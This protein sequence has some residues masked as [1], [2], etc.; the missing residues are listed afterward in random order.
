MLI[1]LMLT[2]LMLIQ[3]MPKQRQGSTFSALV[4]LFGLL[5]LLA[6]PVLQAQDP[7]QSNQSNQSSNTQQLLGAR[8]NDFLPVEEAFQLN[9]QMGQEELLLHWDIAPDYYLYKAR[10][11]LSAEPQPQGFTL[12]FADNT[13]EIYD[14]YFEKNMDVYYEQAQIRIALPTQTEPFTLRLESQGCADA[15]LCYPPQTQYL[16]VDPESGQVN[17]TAAAGPGPGSSGSASG[18]ESET[19]AQIWLPYVL[20]MAL[21]GGLILNLMP[22]VF[23]VLSIKVMSL[24]QADPERLGRHGWAYAA[25]IVLSF[26]AFAGVLMLARAG[27]EAVG[28]GFQLQSPLLIAALAYLFFVLGLSLSGMISIGTRWMGLGQRLTERGGLSGSFFT[29]VLAALVASPCTAP[30]MGAAVGFALT[31][32]ISIS[33]SVFAA[34]GLGMALPLLLLCHLPGLAHRLPKPGAWMD[35]FKQ[36][37]AFPLYLTAIWLLWVLGQQAGINAVAALCTGALLI[38]FALWLSHRQAAG[39]TGRWAL[40]LSIGLAGLLALALPWQVIEQRNDSPR[41]QAYSPGKLES[42]RAQGQPV[43][44]NLTAAWCITCL[45]NERVTLNTERIQNAFE[46]AGVVQLK[47]DWTNYDPQITQLL[48]QYGRSGVPLYLWF[49]ANGSGPGQVLPQLLRQHHLLELVGNQKDLNLAEY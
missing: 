30:F 47:G 15:G 1:Q 20:L 22:C 21:L 36:A 18:I 11:K 46:Q 26:L 8:D 2:Q 3:L 25:G 37:M 48:E 7:F 40:K 41:W 16:E 31:Q 35:T 49:P 24:T 6:S 9:P 12:Q 33:L 10:F 27:G 4:G 13:R 17:L 44:V 39:S 23:P 43:F 19:L 14:E 38:L 32:P 45:A 5:L 34:L 28:W 29:G 42:A